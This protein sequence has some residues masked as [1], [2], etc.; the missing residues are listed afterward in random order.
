MFLFS[1][2]LIDQTIKV[3]KEE[4]NL[5]LSVEQ[6]NEYLN[7]LAELFLAFADNTASDEFGV[8][9]QPSKRRTETPIVGADKQLAY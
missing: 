3:F 5:V 2:K 7:N 1:Q 8:A 9:V 4:N 6:A